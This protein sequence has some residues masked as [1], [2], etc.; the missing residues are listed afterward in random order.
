MLDPFAGVGTVPAMADAMNRVGAGVDIAPSYVAAFEETLNRAHEWTF[1]RRLELEES[2]SRHDVFRQTIVEL[3][4]LKFGA[5]IC[6]RLTQT[7][8]AVRSL[9][10]A[11]S[12]TPPT[13]KFRIVTGTFEAEVDD[14]RACDGLL[15]FLRNIS[16]TRPLSKFGIEPIFSVSTSR[17]SPPRYWFKNGKFWDAPYTV[18][19]E[20]DEIQLT[21][22]FK[23]RIA[24]VVEAQS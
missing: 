7:G 21:S 3:R 6:K 22:D 17:P 19:P 14:L 9:H 5:L 4:L 20:T 11:S 24:D 8:F 18:N 2:R 13:G 1:K 15:D 12:A 23:P 16:G 10:V